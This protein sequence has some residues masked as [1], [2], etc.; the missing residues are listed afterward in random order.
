[1]KTPVLALLL[2]AAALAQGAAWAA[3]P[4][5]L[6]VVESVEIKAPPAKVWDVQAPEGL[7]PGLYYRHPKGVKQALAR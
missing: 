1:M 5:T 3:P 6:H 4:A 7:H 2:G